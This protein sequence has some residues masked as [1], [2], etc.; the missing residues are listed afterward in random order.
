MTED[1][2]CDLDCVFAAFAIAK[3][4]AKASDFTRLYHHSLICAAA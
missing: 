4:P 2:K 3:V 1:E